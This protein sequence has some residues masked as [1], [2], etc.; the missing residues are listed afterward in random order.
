MSTCAASH[1]PPGALAA[2]RG[3][4]WHTLLGQRG[5]APNSGSPWVWASEPS[6]GG[7]WVSA[8][9][10]SEESARR[11]FEARWSGAGAASTLRRE[12]GG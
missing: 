7:G 6:S 4:R 12:P 9:A 10:P 2:R 3:R 5:G 11:C 8:D 1:L